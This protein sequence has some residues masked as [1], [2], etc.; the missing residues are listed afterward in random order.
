[1]IIFPA[2]DI[3]KSGTR[4]EELLLTPPE[5]E[6]VWSIRRSLGKD[7]SQDVTEKILSRLVRTKTNREFIESILKMKKTKEGEN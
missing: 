2:I 1:M 4:K 5:R 7:Q 3:Y 6:A